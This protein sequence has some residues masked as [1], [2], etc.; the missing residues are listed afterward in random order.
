MSAAVKSM[1]LRAPVSIH[2]EPVWGT[3]VWSRLGWRSALSVR[4]DSR[5]AG[6]ID[7]HLDT[8]TV[9][10]ETIGVSPSAPYPRRCRAE[11]P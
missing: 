2:V 6:C 11:S 8:C 3:L 4:G 9:A 7:A 10:F 1:H 5:R